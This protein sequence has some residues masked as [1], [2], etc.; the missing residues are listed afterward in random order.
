MTVTAE[1][2]SV[3][4]LLHVLEVKYSYWTVPPA[5]P[6]APLRVAESWTELPAVIVEEER[7][8]AMEVLFRKFAVTVPEP[9]IVAVVEDDVELVNVMEPVLEDQ[10][11]NAYPELAVADMELV[12]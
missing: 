10:V 5:V 7:V 9:V 4:P 6:V 11:E 1:P 2:T 3:R 8:V 12:P